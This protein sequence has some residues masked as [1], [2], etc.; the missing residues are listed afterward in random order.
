MN[1]NER[2][3]YLINDE[4]AS[5]LRNAVQHVLTIFPPGRLERDE[6]EQQARAFLLSYAGILP[7]WHYN[8]LSDVEQVAHPRALLADKLRKDLKHHFSN[9]LAKVP[10]MYSL[11]E[12]IEKEADPLDEYLEDRIIERID[13]EQSVYALYPYLTM[14]V[15]DGLLLRDIAV[16]MGVSEP[17]VD[18]RIAKEK[19][20][21][22]ANHVIN[23]ELQKAA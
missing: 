2:A 9:Q 14:S 10:P 4:Y 16:K 6:V 17:T 3:E 23:Q 11:S 20:L 5:V 19:A 8:C 12:V 13:A 7:G 22:V 18:R 21:F 15:L 1:D